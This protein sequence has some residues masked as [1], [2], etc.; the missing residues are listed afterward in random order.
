[1]VDM[2]SPPTHEES[3]EPERDIEGVDSEGEDLL[4]HVQAV[5]GS[6]ATDP[7][8]REEEPEVLINPDPVNDP[9]DAI[10][11]QSPPGQ[12]Q[13]P[14]AAGRLIPAWMEDL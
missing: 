7:E 5:A 3:G 6:P 12:Y 1:M 11:K 2:I 8:V 4:P 13:P 9:E 10:E 14:L